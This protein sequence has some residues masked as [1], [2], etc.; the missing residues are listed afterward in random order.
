MEFVRLPHSSANVNV[1]SNPGMIQLISIG[2][3]TA[4]SLYI[5]HFPE[6]LPLIFARSMVKESKSHVYMFA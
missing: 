3:V 2:G 1:T 6:G 4:R 5:D